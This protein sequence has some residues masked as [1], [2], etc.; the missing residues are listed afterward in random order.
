MRTHASGHATTLGIK[1]KVEKAKACSRDEGDEDDEEDNEGNANNNGG[2]GQ[3]DEKQLAK[4]VYKNSFK[5]L[6]F[7]MYFEDFFPADDDR[8]AL[9]FDC[10][11]AGAKVTSGLTK[12]HGALKR[13]LYR[14]KYDKKVR[15]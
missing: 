14:H 13:M 10:W 12:D 6:K 7:K 15:C 5:I 3:S 9:V 8:D 4:R 11:M 1:V 2:D